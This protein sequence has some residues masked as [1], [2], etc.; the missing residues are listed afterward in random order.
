VFAIQDE[1]SRGIANELRLTLSPG[2]RRSE[3]NFEAYDLYL[4]GRHTMS[5]FPTRGRPIASAAFQYFEEAIRK[6]A[7]YALAYAGLADAHLAVDRNMGGTVPGAL[8]KARA[9]AE[10]AIELDP[11]LSEAHSAVASIRARDYAWQDAERG[12]RQAIELNPNNALAH[13]ELGASVLV[14]Q[15]RFEE[16]LEEV[17]AAVALDPLSPY[18]ATEF[19]RA[20]L[21]AGRYKEAVEVLRKAIALDPS[22]NRPHTAMARALYLQGDVNEA[23]MVYD[24]TITRGATLIASEWRACAEVR[25]GRREKALAILQEQLSTARPAR[26][27]AET[28]AC[29]GEE[30][31]ALDF[32][33]QAVVEHQPGI[34]EL[35][36]AE[37]LAWMRQSPR[38]SMLRTRV[39]LAK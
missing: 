5:S 2:S 4:R 19:G 25:A 22:R 35:L 30:Q 9:A 7:N 33:E 32:L 3:T 28:C 1:I 17:R 38:F 6:D 8:S 15:G 29:L 16:G 34:A 21:L 39:N 27:L 26:R 36:Q 24:D 11:M 14:V 12:F 18:V 10:K 13:L 37:E 31:R 23:L 20:L